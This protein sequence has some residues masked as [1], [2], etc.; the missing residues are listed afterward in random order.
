[1]K[2]INSSKK[3]NFLKCKKWLSYNESAGQEFESVK[4]L[5]F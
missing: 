5:L 4:R 2:N 1:M 3:N